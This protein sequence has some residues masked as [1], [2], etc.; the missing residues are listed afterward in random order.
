[1]I[2]VAGAAGNVGAEEVA[3]ADAGADSRSFP[4]WA[5]DHRDAF[6]S[7]CVRRKRSMRTSASSR[8]G[9]AVA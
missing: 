7:P 1:M 6:G 3:V 9:S 2:L 8:R 5:H 4:Q